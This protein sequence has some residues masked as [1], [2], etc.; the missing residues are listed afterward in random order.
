MLNFLQ[1]VL[2]I[3][4]GMFIFGKARHMILFEI[5]LSSSVKQISLVGFLYVY[6]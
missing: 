2:D 3:S 5:L 4:L 1:G 6:L